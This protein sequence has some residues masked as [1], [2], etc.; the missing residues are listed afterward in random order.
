MSKVDRGAALQVLVAA[1]TL[2]ALFCGAGVAWATES[3]DGNNTIA[4]RQK[5]P[6]NADFSFEAIPTITPEGQPVAYLKAKD[7]DVAADATFAITLDS[8]PGSGQRNHLTLPQDGVAGAIAAGSRFSFAADEAL[9]ITIDP[10]G[11]RY[12][13]FQVTD[14]QQL[15]DRHSGYQ[16]R[17]AL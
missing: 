10:A 13:G 4:R 2:S 8:S 17:V 12:V 11:A 15:A 7:V 5:T 16:K 14:P 3:S 9:V 1:G 6:S